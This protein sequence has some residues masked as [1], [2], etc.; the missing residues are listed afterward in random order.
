M[1]KPTKGF[2]KEVEA[3]KA[4]RPLK[5]RA[6]TLTELFHREATRGDE[7]KANRDYVRDELLEVLDRMGTNRHMVGEE[8]GVE[9]REDQP[10]LSPDPAIRDRQIHQLEL[11]ARRKFPKGAPKPVTSHP[12]VIYQLN[13]RFLDYIKNKSDAQRRVKQIVPPVVKLC[14][15]GKGCETEESG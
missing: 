6:D 8:Y 13:P 5:E 14:R 10:K 15:L 11:Y 12:A 7:G 3:A 1:A 9:V 4:K 2:V